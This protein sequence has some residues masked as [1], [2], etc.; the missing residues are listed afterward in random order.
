MKLRRI[1]RQSNVFAMRQRAQILLAWDSKLAT[2]EIARVLQTDE[3]QARR[4]IAESEIGL[5]SE[6]DRCPAQ[7][8]IDIDARGGPATM[9]RSTLSAIATR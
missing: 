8:F 1:S 6:A 7:G 4:V 3:N 9:H 2:G 5:S